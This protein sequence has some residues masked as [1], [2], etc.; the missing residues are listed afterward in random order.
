MLKQ[1]RI[2]IIGAGMSGLL[3]AIRLL[4][5]GNRN[6]VIYEKRDTLG[7]TWRDNVYPGLQCDV[8]AHMFTYSF[9]PNPE[10]STRFPKGDE[11]QEYLERV[12]K[13][14]KIEKLIHYEKT[15][16]SAVHQ[17]GNWTVQTSDGAVEVFDVIICATGILHHPNLPDIPGRDCFGGISFHTARWNRAANLKGQR[18]G[19]IGT[20]AT[21]VQ[22][23]PEMVGFA[24]HL[25][26]FQRTPQWIFPMP[27]KT[28]SENQKQRVRS[29]PRLAARLRWIYSK[30]FQWTF[31]RAVIGNPFLLFAIQKLCQSH[32]NRKV[33]DP[34]LRAKLTPKFQA[35][36]KRLIFGKGFYQAMQSP[37]AS[38]VCEDIISI[39]ETGVNTIDGRHHKLDV[40]IYA[41]GFRAHD[42]MR[43]ML[44]MG[45]SGRTMNQAWNQGAYAHRS[46]MVP[47]FPNFFLIFG[48][49]SPIGNY[50][51]ISVAEVQ[52]NYIL[53]LLKLL[54]TTHNNLIEPIEQKTR[55]LQKK[56]EVASRKTVWLSGCRS[57]YIDPHGRTT[58]WPWT[59]ERFERELSKVSVR[60]FSLFKKANVEL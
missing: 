39:D 26:L 1:P 22:I 48:P 46:T 21:A 34:S 9:E 2:L 54:E 60:E 25:S 10:Y 4:Q 29:S 17:A 19:V 6:I 30:L 24:A 55:A 56:L 18:V 31:S 44:V 42:Y 33:K 20:G 11:I 8:P 50:S 37:N 35:G 15:V 57:W 5:S 23:V 59:F 7:G 51:A 52:V 16:D 3:S 28:Y 47:G 14:Y 40:L 32:L 38:L 13:K 58:M 53:K 12:C 27:N 45:P 43:P 49:Y 36:C 41:T